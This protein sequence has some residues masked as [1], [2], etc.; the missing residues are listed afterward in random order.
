MYPTRNQISAVRKILKNSNTKKIFNKYLTDQSKQANN[1]IP[2]DQ[3]WV[4][5]WLVQDGRREHLT[6]LL[7]NQAPILPYPLVV[8]LVHEIKRS[9]NNR[10]Q[11]RFITEATKETIR[12]LYQQ[13][14]QENNKAQLLEKLTNQQSRAEIGERAATMIDN[15]LQVFDNNNNEFAEP[16]IFKIP[17]ILRDDNDAPSPPQQP[18][19]QQQPQQQQ[20]VYPPPPV[21]SSRSSSKS[22]RSSI[23][24]P[25]QSSGFPVKQEILNQPRIYKAPVE[26]GE[27]KDPNTYE[28]PK[29][30]DWLQWGRPNEEYFLSTLWIL[31]LPSESQDFQMKLSKELSSVLSEYKDYDNNYK[32]FY[33]QFPPIP[34]RKLGRPHPPPVQYISHTK[35]SYE[36]FELPPFNIWVMNKRPDV[37]LFIDGV[38]K[39]KFSKETP[40][41]QDKIQKWASNIIEGYKSYDLKNKKRSVI[42]KAATQRADSQKVDSQEADTQKATQSVTQKKKPPEKQEGDLK[43]ISPFTNKTIF[44]PTYEEWIFHGKPDYLKMKEKWNLHPN[45]N[46]QWLKEISTKIKQKIVYYRNRY[47]NE[48]D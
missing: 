38:W 30:D 2:Y 23:A 3:N 5:T 33:N 37:S 28:I 29:Y 45:E 6:S 47:E 48:G 4:N 41:D 27:E 42:Q 14:K 43:F 35:K 1:I 24:P 19:P 26:K 9:N 22:S 39:N 15:I 16:R 10:L 44:I 13:L 32:K 25:S 11:H 21:L 34:G 46:M 7:D 36:T 8:K 31:T 17:K 40:E 12:L 20:V 18:Q